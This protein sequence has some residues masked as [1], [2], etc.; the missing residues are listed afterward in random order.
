MSNK[1]I[2][3]STILGAKILITKY[4]SLEERWYCSAIN[5]EKTFINP[6]ETGAKKV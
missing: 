6:R 4:L 5:K 3:R 1:T 2:D